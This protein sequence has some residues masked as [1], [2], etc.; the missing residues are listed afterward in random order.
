MDNPYGYGS[1]APLV[2]LFFIIYAVAFGIAIL[3]ALIVYVLDGFAFMKLFRKV[4]IEPWAAW[5]PVFNT[6]RILE[7]GGQPGWLA[8][9]ALIP[10][11]S[12]VTTVF[13][14]IGAYK[15]GVAFRKD[16]SWVVL[17]IFLPFVWAWMLAADGL[18]YEP[19]LIAQ[20]GYRPP[21]VG[22]GSVRGPYVPPTPPPAPTA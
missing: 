11:G 10:Y 1:G 20:R 14:C 6:W 15:T 4:G 3:L 18:P 9:I 12:T 7:M 13:E 2:S 8:V 19:G 21:L 5:V 16:G 17:F 22:F